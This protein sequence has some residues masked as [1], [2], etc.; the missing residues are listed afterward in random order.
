MHQPEVKTNTTALVTPAA[1]RSA[2]QAP[3]QFSA[4]ARVNTP[5]VTSPARI[6][7]IKRQGGNPGQRDHTHG[8][9]VHSS[10][11]SM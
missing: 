2:G 11:P 1:N 9:T 4:I 10:A 7:E 3:G 8:C 5:V 6:S